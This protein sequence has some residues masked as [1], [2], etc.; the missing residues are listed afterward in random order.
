M[1]QI[2]AH[3]SLPIIDI[4]ALSTEPR[5]FTDS[6]KIILFLILS[7]RLWFPLSNMESKT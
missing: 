1:F 6:T 7:M 4:K 5:L 2:Y 3:T